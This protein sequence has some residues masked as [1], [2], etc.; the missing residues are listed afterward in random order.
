MSEESK[1]SLRDRLKNGGGF[2]YGNAPVVTVKPKPK[3]MVIG[4]WL[5]AQQ[6]TAGSDDVVTKP[7]DSQRSIAGQLSTMFPRGSIK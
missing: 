7:T 2:D 5:R 6:R 4:P 1:P 3:G